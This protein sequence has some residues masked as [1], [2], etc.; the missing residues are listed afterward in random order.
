[1][2]IQKTLKGPLVKKTVPVSR[3]PKKEE[4]RST[5]IPRLHPEARVI[6]AKPEE[7]IPKPA[8]ITQEPKIA[9]DA[10]KSVP[11][12][13]AHPPVEEKKVEAIKEIG[14]QKE[15]GTEI[16]AQKEELPL[17]PQVKVISA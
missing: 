9:P 16:A 8:S 6:T 1:M 4:P 10:R 13:V 17:G 15:A 7:F 3:K 11:L 5:L 14:S 2:K 12:A